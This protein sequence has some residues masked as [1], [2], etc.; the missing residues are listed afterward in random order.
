MA[1]NL[2]ARH[3][4]AVYCQ[5]DRLF[6]WLMG[7]QWLFGIA[8]V[9]WLSP[10]TWSG[11]IGSTHPHVWTAILL[12]GV[13]NS[14]PILLAVILPG[15]IVT[16]HVIAAGQALTSAI[17]I[18]LSGGRIEMHFHVFG[19]LALLAFY[20]DWRVLVTASSI[21]AADH[22]LRG[23]LWPQ[24]V[25][26]V[27]D[28]SWLRS[29][30]HVAWVIF[31]DVFLILN[32]VRFQAEMREI[33]QRQAQLIAVNEEIEHQVDERTCEL[34]HKNQM[35]ERERERAEAANQSKS[36]FLANM[37]HEIR[38]PMTAILG[39]ADCLMDDGDM[40]RA[41]PSRVETIRT[42]KRNGEH[43]LS[44]IN[45]ILD[46]SKIEAGKME[47]ELVETS[48]A[49]I[50]QDVKTLMQANAEGKGLTW[51]VTSETLL[52]AAIQADPTRMR[53]I[54]VNLVGNAIKFTE[55]GGVRL[56]CRF[57][58]GQQSRLEFDVIDT[59]I[60]MTPQQ[61]QAIFQPFSQADASTTR[62]FGGT[63]LG[64]SISKRL[65]QI[66]GGDVTIVRSAPGVGSHF[67]FTLPTDSSAAQ[68]LVDARDQIVERLAAES[69]A[70][71]S[72]RPAS[73][74]GTRVLLAEDG[75][76]NQRLISL[77]LRKAG[78]QVEVVEHGQL[79]VEKALQANVAAEP[80]D[81]ILMDMQMPLLDGYSATAQLRASG[82]CLPIIAL[83]AHAMNSDRQKCLDAGCDD[84]LG[85][86]IDR[87]RL[88]QT[89]AKFAHSEQ[90][91]TARH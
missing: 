81:V 60:G 12:A 26:G 82:Y 72:Q 80:F 63:G 32:C 42:I 14:L 73:L 58:T 41:P 13:I 59:G 51:H 90:V 31:E 57:T 21:V 83:T 34:A 8:L 70:E 38:T 18:H 2:Y 39:F 69:L 16:R 5:T 17:L 64:L 3:Q 27:L 25:Y 79:A 65:A 46:L 50:L 22:F 68:R 61:Q 35:L 45:D 62:R 11:A 30:E 33:A 56:E 52:P 54:L 78:A 37:S 53:Q 84:H 44:I 76:D 66:L 55:L 74:S 43:L 48:P 47:V 36:E 20:R 71:H 91:P 9:L 67:R 29:L 89:V 85:K 86:P 1:E 15:A 88:V 4:Q 40:G 75:P 87:M 23:W 6:A 49:Q 77:I 10:R 19:S 24:S 28:A 7:A